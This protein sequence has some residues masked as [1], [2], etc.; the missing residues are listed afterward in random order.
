M[1]GSWFVVPKVNVVD[2]PDGGSAL[3]TVHAL[4]FTVAGIACVTADAV[5]GASVVSSP[6][7]P[8]RRR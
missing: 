1:T 4:L 5:A 3:A 8:T 2:G 6:T 7:T